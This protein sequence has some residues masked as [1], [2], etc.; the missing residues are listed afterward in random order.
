MWLESMEMQG[1]WQMVTEWWGEGLCV[2][3]VVRQRGVACV[4]VSMCV[5]ARGISVCLYACRYSKSVHAWSVSVFN[6]TCVCKCVRMCWCVGRQQTGH[7]PRAS[8]YDACLTENPPVISQTIKHTLD[9]STSRLRLTLVSPSGYFFS[10]ARQSLAVMK[11]LASVRSVLAG[12]SRSA[13]VTPAASPN[14]PSKADLRSKQVSCTWN[15][16]RMLDLRNKMF[17]MMVKN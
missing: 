6:S 9:A 8:F 16:F 12:G 2:T 11:W 1:K 17:M 7:T 15:H 13:P 5:H 14:M 3:R 4:H 10:G